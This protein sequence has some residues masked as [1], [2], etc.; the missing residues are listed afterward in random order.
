MLLNHEIRSGKMKNIIIAILFFMVLGLGMYSLVLFFKYE[1]RQVSLSLLS[2]DCLL[3]AMNSNN[4]FTD[5]DSIQKELRHQIIL[6]IGEINEYFINK[7]IEPHLGL[8]F[9][10][11]DVSED[12]HVIES[13]N[14]IKNLYSEL[15]TGNIYSKEYNAILENLFY[16]ERN[17]MDYW[18]SEGKLF[19]VN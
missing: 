17:V 15:D 1:K 10:W 12:N 5:T 18:K 9:G 6:E 19:S 3:S 11:K 16:N 14:K 4:R 13:F 8:M 7:G 2:H